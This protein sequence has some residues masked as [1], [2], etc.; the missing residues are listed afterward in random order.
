M[1]TSRYRSGETVPW[2]LA[3]GASTKISF[4]FLLHWSINSTEIYV[5]LLRKINPFA[6]RADPDQAALQELPDQGLLCLLM[7]LWLDMIPD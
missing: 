7:E 6:N 1:Y 4:A 2:L 5:I 3:D